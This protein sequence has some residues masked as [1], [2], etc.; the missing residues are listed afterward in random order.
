MYKGEK[1]M[2]VN[3][4]SISAHQVSK[5][6]AISLL[7]FLP[8]IA[9]G[10]DLKF[11]FASPNQAVQIAPTEAPGVWYVDRYAPCGFVSPATSPAGKP[12]LEESICASDSAAN[13]PPAY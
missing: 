9:S 7:A 1:E 6:L 8:A 3:F 10:Q 2:A 4:S 12:T 13:R 5:Y 11:N